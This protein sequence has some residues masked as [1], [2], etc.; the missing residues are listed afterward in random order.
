MRHVI[1]TFHM[2]V[3]RSCAEPTS[4]RLLA[5]VGVFAHLGT[6][7]FRMALRKT[8]FADTPPDMRTCFVVRG[9]NGSLAAEMLV[10]DD[11]YHDFVLV[12]A[13]ETLP[14][15]VGPLIVLQLWFKRALHDFPLA[16]FVGKADNDVYFD[17]VRIGAQL[18][19]LPEWCTEK[20]ASLTGSLGP[21]LWGKLET[22]SME[23]QTGLLSAFAYGSSWKGACGA[24]WR[25]T[26]LSSRTNF[27]QRMRFIGP[28]TFA[29]GPLMLL[30]RALVEAVS[31]NTRLR[32]NAIGIADTRMGPLSAEL[33]DTNPVYEDAWLGF[34]LSRAAGSVQRCDG[35]SGSIVMQTA[36]LFRGVYWEQGYRQPWSVSTV[37][38]HMRFKQ[39]R[40]V[41][42]L[43]RDTHGFARAVREKALRNNSRFYGFRLLCRASARQRLCSLAST[44]PSA[45]WLTAQQLQRSSG[46]TAF[47]EKRALSRECTLLHSILHDQRL[48]QML[49]Q[50]W[51]LESS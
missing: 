23:E 11:R 20:N 39:K 31:S 5:V 27:S 26:Q 16:R 14:R 17:L 34:A 46:P 2:E 47:G 4:A 18:R 30:E 24:S 6:R 43:W 32:A 33:R 29:K 45:A 12:D 48:Q 15:A 51:Y 44:H 49:R 35:K 7:D 28:F 36:D 3:G 40:R 13:A 21:W 42:M 50:G 19:M 38:W 41:S 8:A 22:Y 25:E 1:P 37:L 9:V 10:E